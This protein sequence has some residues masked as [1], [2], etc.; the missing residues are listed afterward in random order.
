[1][2]GVP[3]LCNFLQVFLTTKGG[4]IFFFSKV[5]QIWSRFRKDKKKSFQLRGGGVRPKLKF[6]NFFG[7]F[8]FEGFPKDDTSIPPQCDFSSIT[9]YVRQVIF[10]YTT[11][12]FN[13]FFFQKVYILNKRRAKPLL[14]LNQSPDT[15]AAACSPCSPCS[16]FV[17]SQSWVLDTTRQIFRAKRQLIM[18]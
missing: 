18:S 3:Q 2:G 8:F 14:N 7:L 16:G 17:E 1:M 15:G 9:A 13:S 11:F 12:H 4:K 10:L 5:A 6:F